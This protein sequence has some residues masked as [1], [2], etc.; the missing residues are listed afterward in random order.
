MTFM[1]W[2]SVAKIETSCREL[3]TQTFHDSI[4]VRFDNDRTGNF[5]D[6]SRRNLDNS[7]YQFQL[8][9]DV[10]RPAKRKQ[11]SLILMGI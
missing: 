11:K 10:S 4:S 6:L 1:T 2:T 7:L 9:F 3:E 5:L 8:L